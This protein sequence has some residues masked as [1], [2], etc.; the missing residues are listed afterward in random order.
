MDEDSNCMLVANQAVGDVIYAAI[1]D[2]ANEII[3]SIG[4]GQSAGSSE[5]G[6]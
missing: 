3:S 1:F 5:Q 6:F 4:P 2:V